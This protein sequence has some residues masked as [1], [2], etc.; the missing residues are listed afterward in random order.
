LRINTVGRDFDLSRAIGFIGTGVMGAAM[1]RHLMGAGHELNV[2]NRSREKADA[3][4][5]EGA[6]W[7]ESPDAV[8][9]S[10]DVVI[11]MVGYPSDVEEIYLGD[12][13]IVARARPGAL[14]IDM[15]TSSPELARRI[16]EAAKSA[17]LGAL[18]A[19]VTG[20]DRGARE[21]AL[22][23]LV[24]GDED[25]FSAALPI[26]RVMGRIVTR[27]GP[28]GSGQ[29]AKLANQII[30][31]GAML[32]VCE[33]LAFAKRAGVDAGELLNCVSSGAAGSWSL[34]NYGPR[35][36]DGDFAPG[37]FVKHF[38]KD[39]KLAG[40]AARAM[41]MSL[42]GLMTALRQYEKLAEMGCAES[43]TQGLFNLY[44]NIGG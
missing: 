9:A 39:M 32:G 7:R 15:T 4:V 1:A 33:G 16:Y 18:D 14:L 43:G 24:G 44:D 29:T 8:A 25:D 34:S 41:D 2:F 17:G 35:I 13:G 20:G 40:E 6:S 28:P 31:S 12:G 42:E 30:I 27:F 37:F 5:R 21:A 19:P 26:L 38:I 22:S 11:T 10:S 3:L 36:L 23:I